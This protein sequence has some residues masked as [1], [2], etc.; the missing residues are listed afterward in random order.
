MFGWFKKKPKTLMDDIVK[1]TYGNSPPTEPPDLEN[2]V[3]L[4]HEQL[5]MGII[6]IDEVRDIATKLRDGPMPYTTHGLALCAAMNLYRRSESRE[7]LEEAQLLAR[8][9]ALTWAKD[10]LIPPTLLSSFEHS[11]YTRFK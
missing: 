6:G 4:A 9:T 8:M 10:S 7:I 1:A 2:A 11:L 3:E 5:L